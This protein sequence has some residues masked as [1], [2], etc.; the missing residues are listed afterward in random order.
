MEICDKSI[1]VINLKT[2]HIY[3]DK[4]LVAIGN[5]GKHED[6]LLAVGKQASAYP[7]AINPFFNPRV[8]IDD[9]EKE[10]QRKVIFS[11]I[12]III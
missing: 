2:G 10:T 11:P 6:V 7:S 9:F 12:V 5:N 1:K 3:K 4:P 8:I